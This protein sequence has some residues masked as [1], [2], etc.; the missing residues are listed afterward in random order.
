VNN[1][2][3]PRL[4]GESGETEAGVLPGSGR[5]HAATEAG[6]SAR[7]S[8]AATR[9]GADADAG[10]TGAEGAAQQHGVAHS[11][12]GQVVWIETAAVGSAPDIA[13]P[14]A[15]ASSALRTMAANGF[16]VG[17]LRSVCVP[18]LANGYFFLAAS[19]SWIFLRY[20]AG[21]LSKSFLQDLQQSLISWPS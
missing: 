16:M 19:A 8:D 15:H 17:R 21:S 12:H 2:T 4:R 3:E 14:C 9:E 6:G 13:T 10:R 11:L 7:D 18:T 20:L 1:G 5:L